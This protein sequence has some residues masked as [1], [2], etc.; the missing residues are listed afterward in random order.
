MKD[1]FERRKRADGKDDISEGRADGSIVVRRAGRVAEVA[2]GKR[3][4]EGLQVTARCQHGGSELE[5]GQHGVDLEAEVVGLEH[6]PPRG[7]AAL[8]ESRAV[9]QG[10]RGG[11]GVRLRG[12][13][14]GRAGLAE[15]LR[16]EGQHVVQAARRVGLQV[17]QLRHEGVY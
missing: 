9:L 11:P 3:V 1:V 10:H 2:V 16:P 13:R 17:L 7:P 4:V 15:H 8:D 14:V 5:R 6:E 12:G